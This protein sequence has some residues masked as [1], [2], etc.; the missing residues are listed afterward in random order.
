[1]ASSWIVRFSLGWRA[2]APE[3]R[4][5]LERHFSMLPAS[6]TGVAQTWEVM[7]RS[8]TAS[9]AVMDVSDARP[10]SAAATGSHFSL[11]GPRRQ[12]PDRHPLVIPSLRAWHLRIAAQSDR[13]ATIV[14]DESSEPRSAGVSEVKR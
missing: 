8:D 3:E 10:E 9:T 11:G 14:I 13:Q 12:S 2:L 6:G 1:M 5:E 4:Q 7:V